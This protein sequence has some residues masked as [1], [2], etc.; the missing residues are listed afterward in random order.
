ME[1]ETLSFEW[2]YPV[3]GSEFAEKI[4]SVGPA[5]S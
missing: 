2:V 4:L 3:R 1:E 5:L